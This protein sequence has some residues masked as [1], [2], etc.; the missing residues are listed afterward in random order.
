[1]VF[2]GPLSD[3]IEIRERM[4]SYTDAIA[5]NDPVL[6]AANWTEDCVWKVAGF[7]AEGKNKAVALWKQ[8]MSGFSIVIFSGSLGSL[9]VEGDK[10]T[11][12]SHTVEELWS[13]TGEVRRLQGRYDDQFVRIDGRWL[14][15]VRDYTI[16]R[17][18]PVDK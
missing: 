9:T 11:S 7:T 16:V 14:F 5:M 18:I 12:R 10:A 1:M 8:M 15:S 4:E 17:E 13:T 2:T 6:W 3:R